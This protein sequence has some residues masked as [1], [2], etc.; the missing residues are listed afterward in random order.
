MRQNYFI[1]L[2]S[3]RTWRLGAAQLTDARH[4]SRQLGGGRQPRPAD[5][6]HREHLWLDERPPPTLLL[7]LHALS[8]GVLDGTVV[9]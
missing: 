6:G 5:G 4:Q 8:V 9:V 3:L 2:R 1:N 7:A